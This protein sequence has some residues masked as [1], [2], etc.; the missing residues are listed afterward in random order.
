MMGRMVQ[1]GGKGS[2]R[3]D[4]DVYRGLRATLPAVSSALTNRARF[5]ARY[6][7]QYKANTYA[8]RPG[9]WE[10][11]EPNGN[12][13]ASFASHDDAL[14]DAVHHQ[15]YDAQQYGDADRYAEL[16]PLAWTLPLPAA[17]LGK[18]EADFRPVRHLAYNAARNTLKVTS[19]PHGRIPD[20]CRAPKQ[21]LLWGMDPDLVRTAK[22]RRQVA[23]FTSGERKPG[24]VS[25]GDW[26]FNLQHTPKSFTDR[27]LV[28]YGRVMVD[29]SRVCRLIRDLGLARE[30]G[31]AE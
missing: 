23:E 5:E 11:A 8:T 27:D 21:A 20:A 3:V 4:A 30:Y 25:Y 7:V 18:W 1:L 2:Q 10:W 22:A 15:L 29:L 31:L 24:R 19:E 9:T 28:A 12:V 14:T 16:L 13:H 26:L 6:C 17:W